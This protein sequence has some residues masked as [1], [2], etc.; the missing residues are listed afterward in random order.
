MGCTTGSCRM[1]PRSEQYTVVLDTCVLAPMPLCDTLLR[2][3]EEPAVYFP[4]WSTDILREL[5][6]TLTRMGYT[7]AQA[8]R[9]IVAMEAAFEDACVAGYEELVE[10]M[11]NH[12]KDRHV[13]AAAV[14]CGAQAIVT[15]NGKDFPRESAA[16]YDI[17]VL[18]PD[19]FLVEQFHLDEE[20]VIGK[21]AV[22]AAARRIPVDGLLDRL[23]RAVPEFVALLR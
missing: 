2:L 19:R 3:A 20:L 12:P 7:A 18:S 17:E 14:R 15:H 9:R 21:L 5:R 13:L 11:T 23:E 16:M 1:N 22:Q 8:E 4:K 10:A 6:S